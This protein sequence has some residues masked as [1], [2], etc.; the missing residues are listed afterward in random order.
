[1]FSF[2]EN[3]QQPVVGAPTMPVLRRRHAAASMKLINRYI[4]ILIL[5]QQIEHHF[6]E[7]TQ[8]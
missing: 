2:F 4:N 8:R 1:M 7:H 3:G 5:M 6:A